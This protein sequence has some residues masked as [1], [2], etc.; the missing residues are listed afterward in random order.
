MFGNGHFLQK[1]H[2]GQMP[3]L[4]Q[5]H[6]S[7]RILQLQQIS[8]VT[9]V[10]VQPAGALLVLAVR[11]G[12]GYGEDGLLVVG[13]QQGLSRVAVEYQEI[14]FEEFSHDLLGLRVTEEGLLGAGQVD[15]LLNV[16]AYRR[17]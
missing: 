6:P 3:L 12:R 8:V 13:L 4:Q 17:R 10:P 16:E 2:D 15:F 7:L 9:A 1:R 5:F 14:L 11:I